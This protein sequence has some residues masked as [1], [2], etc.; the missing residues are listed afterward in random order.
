MSEMG[1]FLGRSSRRSSPWRAGAAAGSDFFMIP[2][3]SVVTPAWNTWMSHFS[4]SRGAACTKG[5]AISND[6]DS[7]ANFRVRGHL[8]S[9]VGG[10]DA[11][12][13]TKGNGDKLLINHGVIHV[14][15]Y[16][17]SAIAFREIISVR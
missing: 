3:R 10:A 13:I 6:A 16:A 2:F 1:R 7:A 15:S 8:V 11:Q 5:A 9:F 4:P 12:T 14:R 17:E